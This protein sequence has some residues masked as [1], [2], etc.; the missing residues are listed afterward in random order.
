MNDVANLRQVNGG[1]S[2]A[3]RELTAWQDAPSKASTRVPELNDRQDGGT[4][5]VSEGRPR[6]M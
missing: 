3:R 4:A 5:E 2:R 1:G 6:F